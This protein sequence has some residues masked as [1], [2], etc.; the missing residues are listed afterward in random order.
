MITN[1]E[2]VCTLVSIKHN[3]LSSEKMMINLVKERSAIGAPLP[4]TPTHARAL[5]TR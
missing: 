5:S 3:F 2:V 1:K 4:H